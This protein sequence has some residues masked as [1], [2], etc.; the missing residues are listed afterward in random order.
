MDFYN[1][2][3]GPATEPASVT[4]RLHDHGPELEL[5]GHSEIV[6][7]DGTMRGGTPFLIGIIDRDRQE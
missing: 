2:Q 1:F 5:F 6:V 3:A 7:A 4:I